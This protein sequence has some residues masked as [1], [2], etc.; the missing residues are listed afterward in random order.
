[1]DPNTLVGKLVM[2]FIRH[3]VAGLGAGLVTDGLI[4]KAQDQQ[5]VGALMCLIGVGLS[6]A[7]QYA[8]HKAKSADAPPSAPDFTPEPGA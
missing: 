7:N 1:M 3:V 4:T 2:A 8:I 6:A 5:A